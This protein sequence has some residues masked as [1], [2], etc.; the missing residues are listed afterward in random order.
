[1]EQ[2]SFITKYLSKSKYQYQYVL[3]F[4]LTVDISVDRGMF[5]VD[6]S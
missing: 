2:R 1:M 4:R 5:V 3:T 6:N